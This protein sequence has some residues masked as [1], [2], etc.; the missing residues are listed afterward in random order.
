MTEQMKEQ[1]RL[2]GVRMAEPDYLALPKS[3]LSG[4]VSAPKRSWWVRL[5]RWLKG[6]VW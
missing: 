5:W 6:L 2:V 1:Q 4:A 3:I